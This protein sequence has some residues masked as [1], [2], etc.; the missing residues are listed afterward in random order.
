MD[1]EE[2]IE[3]SGR[4]HVIPPPAHTPSMA[5]YC[6]QLILLQEEGALPG[7]ESE[8]LS[9]IWKRTVRE[10]THADIA[11]DFIGKGH[12]D[13]EQAGKGMLENC[14]ATW[15]AVLG[16]M[17]MGLLSRLSLTNH[18]DSESFLVVHALLSQDG[19]Q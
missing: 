18:S 16:F 11:R 17:V 3:L 9:N 8:L 19:C 12:L 4:S 10:D 2:A 13:G 6:L 14:S 1:E 15:L 5:L 7:P